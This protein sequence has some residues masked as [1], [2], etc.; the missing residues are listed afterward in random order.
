MSVSRYA[1][2]QVDALQWVIDTNARVVAKMGD[3]IIDV[4]E[5]LDTMKVFDVNKA[6]VRITTV[7]NVRLNTSTLG[8]S[9]NATLDRPKWIDTRRRP[10]LLLGDGNKRVIDW[11]PTAEDQVWRTF[12]DH[13][14]ET[15]P[16]R[17]VE[18]RRDAWTAVVARVYPLPDNNN[19]VGT[20]YA[21]GDYRIDLPYWTRTDLPGPSEN[22]YFLHHHHK[23]VELKAA[24]AACFF[25]RDR[26][27]A[28]TL[29]TRAA[30]ELKRIKRV[31]KISQLKARVLRPHLGADPSAINAR[32]T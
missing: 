26:D 7:E 20:V 17:Y 3:F 32:R 15:G 22:N 30:A 28:L 24:A 6:T 11:A 12:S 31:E 25:N 16:P 29:E 10:I 5:E 1:Q 14:D 19:I 27:E 4:V 18:I 23:Y 9:Q 21:D 8:G 13:P 2:I